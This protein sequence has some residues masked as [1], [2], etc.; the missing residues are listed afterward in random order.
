MPKIKAYPVPPLEIKTYVVEAHG[1]NDGDKDGLASHWHRVI[2][3]KTNKDDAI[4]LAQNPP[5]EANRGAQVWEFV[6]NGKV[7]TGIKIYVQDVR[8]PN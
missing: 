7:D 8:H 3:V 6:L 5:A 2:A 1:W 4:K